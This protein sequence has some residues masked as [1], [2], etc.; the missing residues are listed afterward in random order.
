MQLPLQAFFHTTN[1]SMW[2]NNCGPRPCC[3]IKPTFNSSRLN[4]TCLGSPGRPACTGTFTSGVLPRALPSPTPVR[5]YQA[6]DLSNALP[7]NRTRL[8]LPGDYKPWVS[9]LGNGDV[10]IVAFASAPGSQTHSDG[11]GGTEEH[12]VFWRSAD[13]GISYSPREYRTDLNGREW[14][15]NVLEDSTL[16]MPNA[17]LASDKNFVRYS[18]DCPLLPLCPLSLFLCLC[19]SLTRTPMVN[20]DCE[21]NGTYTWLHRSTDH[22]LTWTHLPIGPKGSD[23]GWSIWQHSGLTYFG[24]NMGTP[25]LWKSSDSGI[26]WDRHD[27]TKVKSQGWY[28]FCKAEHRCWLRAS[29]CLAVLTEINSA[30]LRCA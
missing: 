20:T 1:A 11:G 6:Q 12:A 14:S 19:R 25:E 18:P 22:G 30:H 16:L 21:Q 8:G 28:D 2:N 15:L 4:D 9:I 27:A 17:L 7:T 5:V 23:Y 29:I 13:Q 26:S 10:L 3:W 24:V